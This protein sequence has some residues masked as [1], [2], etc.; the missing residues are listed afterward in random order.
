MQTVLK[1][2]NGSLLQHLMTSSLVNIPSSEQRDT[3]W[4][5]I[6]SVGRTQA[7]IVSPVW[8]EGIC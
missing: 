6:A 1:H 8:E 3:G 5:S 2:Q 7:A 4:N